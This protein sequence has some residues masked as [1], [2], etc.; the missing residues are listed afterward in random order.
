MKDI[1]CRKQGYCLVP[2]QKYDSDEL[3]AVPNNALVRVRVTQPRN[4]QH[5]RLYWAVLSKVYENTD[6][7]P[8]I[9]GLHY[10]LKIKA[11]YVDHITV[12]EGETTI[13]PKSI[14]FAAMDQTQFKDYFEA[15]M[16]VIST[17]VLPGTDPTTLFEEVETA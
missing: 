11:G 15:A 8:S 2:E 9:E 3:D 17:E 14:S 5:H 6:C 7:F 1:Y 12:R 4:P 10:W 16:S 13:I